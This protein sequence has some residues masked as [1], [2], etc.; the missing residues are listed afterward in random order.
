MT[1]FPPSGVRPQRGKHGAKK[2]IYSNY[3]GSNHGG[4]RG[5]VEKSILSQEQYIS[6]QSSGAAVIAQRPTQKSAKDGGEVHGKWNVGTVVRVGRNPHGCNHWLCEGVLSYAS[7][8]AKKAYGY[9]R[10]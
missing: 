2:C 7:E 1:S 3:A 9:S 4:T 5:V 6:H 8:G 10:R